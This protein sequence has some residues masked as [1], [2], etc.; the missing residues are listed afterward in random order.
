[1][2]AN[3]V[4]LEMFGYS[5][6]DEIEGMPIMDMVAPTDH[7]RFKKFLRSSMQKGEDLQG[8]LEVRGMRA[9]GSE[10]D[11][12]MEFTP[13]SIE[14]ESCTQIIMRGQSDKELQQ[15]LSHLSKQ[16]LLTGLYN[17]QYFMETL[18]AAVATA[19]AEGQSGAL[20]FIDLDN[21]DAITESVGIA[22][23]DLVLGDVAKLIAEFISE[24]EICARFGDHS[25]TALLPD[26]S[27]KDAE[28]LEA[29]AQIAV[30]PLR[31]EPDAVQTV[32]LVEMFRE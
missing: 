32:P 30:Y 13:A 7:E 17:R 4:Y 18:E 3:N 9:D 28:V 2:Y 12:V 25:F 27:P 21:F 22:T 16:D 24:P 6:P 20:L 26:A 23:S 29:D 5:D 31:I 15:Q 8:E 19:S 1:M 11:A 10:F 14:G